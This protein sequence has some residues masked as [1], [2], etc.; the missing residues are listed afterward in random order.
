VFLV[1]V[2]PP[3]RYHLTSAKFAIVFPSMRYTRRRDEK[4]CQLII[5]TILKLCYTYICG[6]GRCYVT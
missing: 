6:L 4:F 5:Y 3:E 2:V 1:P